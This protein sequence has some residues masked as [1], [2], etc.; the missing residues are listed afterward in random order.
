MKPHSVYKQHPAV[1]IFIQIFTLLLLS[2]WMSVA[3]AR[4]MEVT[5]SATPDPAVAGEELIYTVAYKN[6][7][8]NACPKAKL[9]L[10][11]PQHVGS[12]SGTTKSWDLRT[13]PGGRHGSRQ[14][15]VKVDSPLAPNT[16]LKTTASVTSTGAV[17]CETTVTDSTNVRPALQ[18]IK[19]SSVG[20]VD[21]GDPLTYTLHYDN[22]GKG[23]ASNVIL[24]DT[25]PG[26]ASFA[27][28]TGNPSVS[29]SNIT[30]NLGTVIAGAQGSVTL[31]VDVDRPPANGVLTNTGTI[32]STETDPS[33]FSLDVNVHSEPVLTLTK[34]AS[35]DPV[36]PGDHLLYNLHYENTGT[37]EASNLVLQDMLPIGVTF[38]SAS[39]GGSL[40]GN[41]VSWNLADLPPNHSGDLILAVIVDSTVVN[42]H[43]LENAATL[44]SDE[45]HPIIAQEDITVLAEPAFEI[46]KT[47]S[48]KPVN[49]GDELIYTIN[50]RNIGS[51]QGTGIIIEDNLPPGVTFKSAS[52]SGSESGGKVTWNLA[53][54]SAGAS[55][56]VTVTVT[57]NSPLANG[58]ILLNTVSIVST[59]TAPH[60]VTDVI[61]VIVHSEPVL[62]LRNKHE[63][64]SRY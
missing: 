43:I 2:A 24:Q 41:I 51:G 47:A 15:R 32:D 10:T 61:D 45:T 62:K 54:L 37:A 28:A 1:A 29:G 3:H 55:G 27:S 36:S 19:T 9:H 40:S 49:P 25:L 6:I 44:D 12:A 22:A 39:N 57:V 34:T 58:T 26:D 56:S 52:S 48:K 60:K 46:T 5:I 38:D 50:Y 63:T 11:L 20:M 7:T 16:E 13:L 59:E 4:A 30:W 42:G 23:N 14:V 17:T 53:A 8:G 21:V 31:T 33:P 35:Q 64:T 18:V